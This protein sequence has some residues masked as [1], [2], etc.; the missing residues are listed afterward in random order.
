MNMT[1]KESKA[2]ARYDPEMEREPYTDDEYRVV[3]TPDPAGD[4]VKFTDHQSALHAAEA[5][6]GEL[7]RKVIAASG[8]VEGLTLDYAKWIYGKTKQHDFV[9]EAAS[10]ITQLRQLL[11]SDGGADGDDEGEG[12]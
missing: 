7:R 5:E 9:A 12:K 10:Y 8:L 1:A 11:A 2:V 6:L 3:M 4:Y